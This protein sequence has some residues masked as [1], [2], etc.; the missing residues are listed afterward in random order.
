VL[1]ADVRFEGF[2]Q[3]DWSRVLSLFAPR[4]AEGAERDPE[5]PRGGVIAVHGGGRIRKLVHTEVGRL[6]LD[7]LLDAW[8]LDA[9]ELARR[10]HASWSVVVEMG[11]LEEIMESF[12]ARA[13]RDDDFTTQLLL[14]VGLVREQILEGRIEHWPV[15]LAGMPVPTTGMVSRTLDA[16]CPREQVIAL[17]LFDGGELYTSIALRRGASGNVDW[18]VGPDELRRDMGLLAGDWRRDHRHLARAV[19]R[20]MGRIAMGV[21]AETATL[22]RLE[23][24]ATPGA[25][26]KAVAVRDVILQPVPVALALPLGI[27]AGRAAVSAL[28]DVIDRAGASEAAGPLL[29][30]VRS[31][32]GDLADALGL[33]PAPGAV[34]GLEFDPLELLRRLLVRDR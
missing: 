22:R 21:Y 5:R 10:H 12:G 31:T 18:I 14:L 13:R 7:D 33:T 24:D 29:G 20:R 4:R 3:T 11:A 34:A 17:G 32:L 1:S 6:R 28:R 16:I 8:P 15:R 19:E 30:S 25:W 26:A 9:A 23:V 2:T 27:D